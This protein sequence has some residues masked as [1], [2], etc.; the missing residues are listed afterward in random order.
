MGVYELSGAGSVKTQRTNY[1]SMNANNQFGAMVPI[2]SQSFAGA[3]ASI[4]F[5]NIPQTYQDLYVVV[6]G[7]DSRAVTTESMLY[8]INND[9]SG[10]YS[11]SWLYGTGASAASSRQSNQ[12]FY[13]AASQLTGASA[14]AGIFGSGITHILN[15]A[16]SS[17]FKTFLSRGSADLNGSGETTL[18]TGLYRSTNPV[19]SLQVVSYNNLDTGS[20]ITLYGIRASNS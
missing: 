3:T 17:N 20:T 15:Y 12:G 18:V 11:Y 8:A 5:L 14:T 9:T 19:T 10:V 2:G 7:R 13:V 16:N 4:S 6:Y 1:K